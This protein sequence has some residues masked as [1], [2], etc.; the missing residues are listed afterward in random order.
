MENELK[1]LKT[2]LTAL[3]RKIQLTLA[4]IDKSED[5]QQ[6]KTPK[7]EAHKN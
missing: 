6:S 2:E 4:P 3:D 1:D 5:E 7:F